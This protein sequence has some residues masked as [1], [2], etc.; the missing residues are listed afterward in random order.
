[1][2]VAMIEDKETTLIL[3]NGI[4]FTDNLD[5]PSM[6]LLQQKTFSRL[7][8]EINCSTKDNP[9]VINDNY[10][11]INSNDMAN[12]KKLA[13]DNQNMSFEMENQPEILS[14][15]DRGHINNEVVSAPSITEKVPIIMSNNE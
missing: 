8:K 5:M 13:N 15:N 10:K 12:E 4:T 2:N 11:T 9:I 6:V 3:S 14:N 7:L 1:M